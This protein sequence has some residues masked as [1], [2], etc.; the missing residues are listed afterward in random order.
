MFT[1]RR[2][3]GRATALISAA[4]TG[5]AHTP[6]VVAQELRDR[7]KQIGGRIIQR[8]DT[9]YELWRASMVWYIFKPDR[10]PDTIIRAESEQDVIESVNYAR[11]SGLRI[12]TRATGHNPARGCLRDGGMLLDTSHFMGVE[13][14][15]KAG[16]AWI[17]PGIRSQ[18]LIE[19]I[20][21]HGWSFPAAHTG[22][23]GL[24]GYLIGGGLGWNMS[25]WDIAC[26]SI[27]GAEIVLADGRKIVASTEEHADL[28]WAIRGIG[29]GF[30]G[31]VLRYKLKL[32][33]VPR[34]II[35]SKYI[36]PMERTAELMEVLGEITANK[37]KQLE[38]LAVAGRFVPPDKPPAERDFTWAVSA[39]SFGRSEADGIELLEPVR[40]S[41]LPSMS[42]MQK[43]DAVLTYPELYAGQETDHSSPNRTAIHNIWTDD[44]GGALTTLA[45]RWQKTPPRS[46]RSFALSAWGINPSPDDTDSAFTYTGDHYLSWYLMAE[47]ADDVEP[48]FR[49]MDESVQALRPYARGHYP[50][51]INM[52]RYPD[53]IRACFT[54]EKWRRLAELRKKYDPRGV[55]HSYLGF[56]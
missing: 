41:K 13:I 43:E 4:W 23:V 52:Q 31:T 25:E 48:N 24:G 42:S 44:P 40:S 15:A 9:N 20:R 21:P 32:F 49:W 53:T 46:P 3:I 47:Q 39:I 8:A 12:A 35:K 11:D 33:P 16:T 26:R 45:E 36:V 28:L 10:Y 2:F 27:I 1:R 18:D 30:F 22:I 34:G 6:V 54:E 17:E 50:N 37:K 38:I 19:L 29:P 14:D 5:I 7:L 51:E 55:F 56:S